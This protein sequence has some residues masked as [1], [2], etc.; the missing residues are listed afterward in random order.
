MARELDGG[1]D[2]M[3]GSG[4]VWFADLEPDAPRGDERE[5]DDLADPG[6]GRLG[7]PC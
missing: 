7:R 3:S 6:M 2:N 4:E 5:V 1:L